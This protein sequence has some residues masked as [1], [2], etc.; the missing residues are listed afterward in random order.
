MTDTQTAHDASLVQELRDQAALLLR[1]AARVEG[2]PIP[3]SVAVCDWEAPDAPAVGPWG[4]RT[5]LGEVGPAA[6]LHVLLA[7]PGV[8]VIPLTADDA[9]QLAGDLE[10]L[11]AVI[12]D[13]AR[14][15][16]TPTD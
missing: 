15:T 5:N 4:L 2:T 13:E 10:T 1:A 7:V 14:V 16:A 6:E 11:V 9:E 12:R 3:E 8:P